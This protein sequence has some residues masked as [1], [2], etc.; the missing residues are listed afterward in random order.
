MCCCICFAVVLLSL[1]LLSDAMTPRRVIDHGDGTAQVIMINNGYLRPSIHAD[2][3]DTQRM[4]PIQVPVL[5]FVIEK[6]GKKYLW[7]R[8][9]PAL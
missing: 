3:Y 2:W 8:D 7:V 6:E 5:C 9:R 4:D 1:R